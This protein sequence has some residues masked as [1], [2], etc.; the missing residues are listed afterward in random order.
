MTDQT[1]ELAEDCS[2]K[3]LRVA[4]PEVREVLVPIQEDDT[5]EEPK[6]LDA[7]AELTEEELEE[8][9]KNAK[10]FLPVFFHRIVHDAFRQV[11]CSLLVF[12]FLILSCLKCALVLGN[13]CER[14]C[15][16]IFVRVLRSSRV[17]LVM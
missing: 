3:M 8:E 10:C 12:L 2:V 9:F 15:V 5:L 7:I 17:N 11:L 6:T 1:I 14:L 13:C 4:D 16:E